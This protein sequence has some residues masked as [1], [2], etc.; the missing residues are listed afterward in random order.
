[1]KVIYNFFFVTGIC[2]F[3]LISCSS[4]G[5][6][7]LKTV[8]KT[9][10]SVPSQKKSVNK[11]RPQCWIVYDL[12]PDDDPRFEYFS[13]EG[14]GKSKKQSKRIARIHAEKDLSF[15]LVTKVEVEIRSKN[16]CVKNDE[17][18]VCESSGSQEIVNR[19]MSYIQKS[20]IHKDD[21]FCEPNA[22]KCHV[23]I[24]IDKGDLSD[25]LK[26]ARQIMY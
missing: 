13:G 1:M 25:M 8:P 5:S 21:H 4:G 7:A 11:T 20:I 9:E 14:A 3:V 23:R 6:K 12:C 16:Q 17:R 15:Y 24:K 18:E 2:L 19:T 26:Y 10:S 22:Y